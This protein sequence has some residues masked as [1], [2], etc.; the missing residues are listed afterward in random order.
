[1]TTQ[2][3]E[4]TVRADGKSANF[5][6]YDYIHNRMIKWLKVRAKKHPED[7]AMSISEFIRRAMLEKLE[8]DKP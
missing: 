6:Q 8:R 4:R 3:K 1:M 7:P 5:W 2:E